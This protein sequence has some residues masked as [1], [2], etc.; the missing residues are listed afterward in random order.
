MLGLKLS[1]FLSFFFGIKCIKYV[2]LKFY[3]KSI[4]R[5]TLQEWGWKAKWGGRDVAKAL[6]GGEGE[7]EIIIANIIFKICF[8]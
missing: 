8:L 4:L 1:D 7:E 6:R 3:L 5:Q 2:S